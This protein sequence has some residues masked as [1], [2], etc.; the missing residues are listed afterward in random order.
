MTPS[1]RGP[2]AAGAAAG[3]T[4]AAANLF[5]DGDWE[6]YYVSKEFGYNSDDSDNRRW[7]HGEGWKQASDDEVQLVY[8]GDP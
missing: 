4:D 3:A 6:F 8:N 7:L 2:A 1:A 5:S